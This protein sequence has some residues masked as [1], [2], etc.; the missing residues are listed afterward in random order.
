M[1]TQKYMRILVYDTEANGLLGEATKVHCA[2][3]YC[4][5]QVETYDPTRINDFIAQ[6]SSISSDSVIVCHNQ[7]DYDL[8]LIEKLYGYK[9]KGKV[10]D[11]LVFSRL[12]N[13]ERVGGHSLD[14]W[15]ERLGRRKPEHEDW[16]QYSPAMLHRCT[17][18]VK[19]NHLLY[20][21]L[22]KE[23]ELDEE[24]LASLIEY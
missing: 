21:E 18:D 14:A 12:L 5:G 8:P 1:E 4:E 23:A 13:P 3:T 20:K 16:T 22:M 9:H 7:I 11:T 19:I 15:G 17:E 10:L 2:V 6:L 24:R